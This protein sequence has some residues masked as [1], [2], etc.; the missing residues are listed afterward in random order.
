MHDNITFPIIF[1]VL[2]LVDLLMVIQILCLSVRPY[3][4]PSSRAIKS[5]HFP[6]LYSDVSTVTVNFYSELSVIQARLYDAQ[7]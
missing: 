3:L 2:H 1:Y 4:Q 6:Q 7:I 5:L